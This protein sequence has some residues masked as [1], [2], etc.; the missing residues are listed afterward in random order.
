MGGV[1]IVFGGGGFSAGRNWP[2]AK[3]AKLALDALKAHGIKVIDTA[4]IYGDSEAILGELNAGEDFIIDT[5]SK[6]GIEKGKALQP[7]TLYND[8]HE[9]LKRVKVKQFDIFYI[10]AP[11]D[12]VPAETWVPVIDKLHQEG[13]F[14]RFGLSN[15]SPEQVQKV[16]D[17]AK[18]SNY[19]LPSVYQGN[20]SAFARHQETDLFPLLRDLKIAFYAY[21]PLAGGFLT[22]SKEDLLKGETVG[23][24]NIDGLYRNIFVKPAFL[25][26]LAL[27]SS[28]AEEEGISKAELGYRWVNYHSP[29]KASQGDGLIFA[30]R[31]V[32]QL[33]QTVEGLNRGPLKHETVKK[34]DAIWEDIKHEAPKAG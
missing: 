24:F 10:H 4:Q 12:T 11:D 13:V 9:S 3:T 30:A 20:Y 17:V 27:W 28:A 26:A 15:F 16:Y 33:D 8:A 18:V 2:D 31:D 21:S 6:G 14:Q 7:D 22:K 23:R 1:K 34:I 19:T 32:K 29:L 25:D 5:K